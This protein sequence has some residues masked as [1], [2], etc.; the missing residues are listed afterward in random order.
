MRAFASKLLGA[1][2]VWALLP[3]VLPAW[4]GGYWILDRLEYDSHRGYYFH[5]SYTDGNVAHMY[6]RNVR[7]GGTIYVGAD[8][9]LP[10]SINSEGFR[11]SFNPASRI[12]KTPISLVEPKRFFTARKIR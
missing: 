10:S 5:R 3:T 7:S 1:A 11:T 12:S 9:G 2:L 8:S 6:S 4:D